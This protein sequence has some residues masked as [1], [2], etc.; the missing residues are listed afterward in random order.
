MQRSDDD[1]TVFEITYKGIHAC[2]QSINAVPPPASP[3]KQEP[4]HKNS[5]YHH[6]LEQQNQTL[7][8]LKANLRVETTDLD[9]KEMPA[10]FSFPSPFQCHDTE[11][12]FSPISALADDNQL[13]TYSP[14]F[15]SPAT[16][17][18]NYF[19]AA[20]YEMKNY[21]GTPMGHSETDIGDIISAHASTTNSPIRGMEFPFD[22][23]DLDPD[24]P[25]NTA[26][27]FI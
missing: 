16:S 25:F 18:S 27:F 2:N 1:P 15:Y 7:L 21:G 8:N 4:R 6:Q 12:Q 23:V 26:G 20:T 13:C 19:S 3:E 11:N 22:P 24:F 14:L 10:H 9:I 17:E 5:L